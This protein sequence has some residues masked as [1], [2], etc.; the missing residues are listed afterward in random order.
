MKYLMFVF[1][2]LYS[3]CYKTLC[4]LNRSI[5][6]KN[7]E[8]DEVTKVY[9]KRNAFCFSSRLFLLGIILYLFDIYMIFI[10]MCSFP[11][12]NF[13]LDHY[14]IVIVILVLSIFL[15]YYCFEKN[16][17]YISYFDKFSKYG[18]LRKIGYGIVGVLLFFLPI[19]TL[20]LL[21]C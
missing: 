6:G 11:I 19:I 9:L 4:V 1:Y 3:V 16:N 7:D 2:M 10:K 20:F 13:I 5:W 21:L 12:K 17:K 18:I 14:G 15:S 8:K